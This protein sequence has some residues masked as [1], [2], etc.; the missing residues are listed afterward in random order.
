MRHPLQ[1]ENPFIRNAEGKNGEING[2][3]TATAGYSEF[4]GSAVEQFSE[5][6]MNRGAFQ[7]EVFSGLRVLCVMMVL[8]YRS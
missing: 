4:P 7:R 6:L 5:C 8:T 1:S 2:G 3:M